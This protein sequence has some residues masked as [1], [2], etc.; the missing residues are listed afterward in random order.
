MPR[1]IATNSITASDNTDYQSI[2]I[3]E[4]I[5]KILTHHAGPGKYCPIKD[6]LAA[7]LNKWSIYCLL[8]LGQKEKLRFNQ[9][10]AGIPGISQRMLTVTLRSLEEHGVIIRTQYD[11]IPLRVDYELSMMG[12]D[13]LRE[14]MGVACWAEQ[15][16]DLI[17]QS[18]IRYAN[19]KL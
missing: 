15:N 3:S 11:E 4:R 12:K 6:T 2:T 17:Q 16:I 18:R 19:K 8:S 7:L 1:D 9:M 5:A 14:L 10:K 13:F